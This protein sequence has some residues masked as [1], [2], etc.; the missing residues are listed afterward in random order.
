MIAYIYIFWSIW[1]IIES[2]NTPEYD[3]Y[4]YTWYSTVAFRWLRLHREHLSSFLV[5]ESLRQ[6]LYAMIAALLLHI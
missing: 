6:C 1:S 4:Y 2:N 3:N 5:A